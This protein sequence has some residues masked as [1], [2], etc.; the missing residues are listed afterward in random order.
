MRSVCILFIFVLI[1]A[2]FSQKFEPQVL[3]FGFLLPGE[4]RTL[5][6]AVSEF[7]ENENLGDVY[8]SQADVTNQQVFSIE[9]EVTSTSSV[10][11]VV[12]Q[13][14][15]FNPTNNTDELV[16][17]LLPVMFRDGTKTNLIRLC[18]RSL[19]VPG[20]NLPCDPEQRLCIIDPNDERAQI[21]TNS[22][23]N[24]NLRILDQFVLHSSAKNKYEIS[25]F[26]F[27]SQIRPK[28][29]W[30]PKL[31]YM[32]PS[33]P[34]DCLKSECRQTHVRPIVFE[35]IP[36]SYLRSK[37]SWK[38]LS[39]S[40]N[41]FSSK[42]MNDV[43]IEIAFPDRVMGNAVFT[44]TYSELMFNSAMPPILKLS[45]GG[46]SFSYKIEC[47]SMA[48]GETYVRTVPRAQE[49]PFSGFIIQH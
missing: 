37:S 47:L 9:P 24:V 22:I 13:V 49:E 42:L 17:G 33:V 43:Q 44:P 19:C 36:G 26:N 25:I 5:T 18:Y 7:S 12:I 39:G 21:L 48:R 29:T 41:E 4:S 14:T 35:R 1:Q 2:S 38:S 8:I 46:R 28:D 15:A 3:N 16:E 23:T 6:L 32:P 27:L 34:P 10:D 45:K 30:M 40:G 11:R 20:S 31:A